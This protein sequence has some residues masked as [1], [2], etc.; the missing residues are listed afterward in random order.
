MKILTLLVALVVAFLGLRH[1]SNRIA[2]HKQA[3]P[4]IAHRFNT[5][6][7]RINQG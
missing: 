2:T 3:L 1:V 6:V 7:H 5:Q 4:G